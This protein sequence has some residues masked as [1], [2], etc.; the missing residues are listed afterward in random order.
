MANSSS[1]FVAPVLSSTN[2]E[3][4][5]LFVC[6]RFVHS[7]RCT[8]TR[9]L[10]LW[11]QDAEE[12]AAVNNFTAKLVGHLQDILNFYISIYAL[13]N[14]QPRNLRMTVVV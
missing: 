11:C 9:K 5:R 3:T 2:A 4:A 1:S 10:L 13:I 14:Y 7:Y 6:D 12:E 8:S